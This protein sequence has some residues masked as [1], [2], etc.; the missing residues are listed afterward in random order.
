VKNR[1]Q[2][3]REGSADHLQGGLLDGG[4]V[5]VPMLAGQGEQGMTQGA[6]LCYDGRGKSFHK[7]F[8]LDR[9]S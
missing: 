7:L 8:F 2:Q 4:Q 3:V 9:R 6:H 1:F 5:T